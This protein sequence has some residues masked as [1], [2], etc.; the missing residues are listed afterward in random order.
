MTAGSMHDRQLT[1]LDM[2]IFFKARWTSDTCLMA[3]VDWKSNN[4]I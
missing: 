2:K 1:H 3:N 4:G